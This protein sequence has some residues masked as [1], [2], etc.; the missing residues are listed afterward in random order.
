[1]PPT[2]LVF[3]PL[4]TGVMGTA[5]AGRVKAES[6]WT[7]LFPGQRS[8]RPSGTAPPR[9]SE[10]RGV[11]PQLPPATAGPAARRVPA[12]VDRAARGVRAHPAGLRG[13]APL[14]LA[15]SDG[16]TARTSEEAAG[17]SQGC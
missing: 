10:P 6:S 17:E 9:Q 14:H 5:R 7:H 12:A 13:A 3:E 2:V 16:D 8:H 11:G 4:V 1:M 15:V